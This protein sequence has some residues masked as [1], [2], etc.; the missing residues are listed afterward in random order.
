MAVDKFALE[1][2]GYKFRWGF[3]D[4]D[5]MKFAGATLVV[6]GGAVSA[7]GAYGK[8][9]SAR[10]E[11]EVQA[12]SLEFE[13]RLS[14]IS[15]RGAELDAQSALAA[16][17]HEIGRLTLAAGQEAGARKART[18][19]SGVRSDQG[20]AARVAASADIRK[21]MDISTIAQNATSRANAARTRATNLRNRSLLNRVSAQNARRMAQS[22]D[23]FM[24]A[25]TSILNSAAAFGGQ[26]ASDA[27]ARPN[28]E[29]A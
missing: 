7:I 10:Y 14:G 16:G 28:L 2:E 1:E 5:A 9:A 4:P 15:A 19:A 20:S 12:L 8:A 6:G 11:G 13:G 22:F 24:A 25:A 26:L 23:P 27:R 17:K 21:E 18:A 3:D 29:T